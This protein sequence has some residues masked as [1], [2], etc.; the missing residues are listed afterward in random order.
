MTAFEAQD[1]DF[2]RRVRESFARQRVM[3][4]MGATLLRVTPGEVEIALPFRAELTQQ[5]GFLHAGVVTTIVDSAC[6]YAALSLMPPG[7]GVLTIEFKLNLMAP[8]A[9]ERMIARGRVTKPG[10]TINV[11][12]GDVF[13]EQNGREKLVATMLATVMT[14]HNRPG[15]TD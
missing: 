15:V 13:A 4:T 6:G 8:A 12:A 11:C 1:P 9:G 14:I 7:A 10:R 3:E 2:E 5:H